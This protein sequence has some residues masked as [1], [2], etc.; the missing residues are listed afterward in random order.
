[1]VLVCNGINELDSSGEVMLSYLVSKL[2][3][4][5][6]DVSFSGTNDHVIDVMK[7]THLYEKVGQDHFFN[8]VQQAVDAIHKGTCLQYGDQDC[9]LL[10]SIHKTAA[11]D[12]S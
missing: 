12:R 3:S 10:H 11:S 4:A 6:I 2:R 9:P 5:G 1:V 7:R 8:T